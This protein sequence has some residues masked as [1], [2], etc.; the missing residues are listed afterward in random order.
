MGGRGGVSCVKSARSVLREGEGEYVTRCSGW[1]HSR[2]S[3]SGRSCVH[4]KHKV[5]NV[6]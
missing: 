4:D 2:W 6:N 5:S 3:V 1:D